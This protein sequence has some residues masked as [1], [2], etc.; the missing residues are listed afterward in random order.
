MKILLFGS[1]GFFGQHIKQAAIEAG[2][3][4]FET[5]GRKRYNLLCPE[6]T[7]MAF[8]DCKKPDLVINAAG[9]NGGLE[10]NRQY[11]ADILVQNVT[12]ANNIVNQARSFNVKNIVFLNAVCA[13]PDKHKRNM[14][15]DMF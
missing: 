7:R 9:H 2:H 5:Y 14:S 1:S 4:V 6:Q 8:L 10:F 11:P 12:M 3:D 15:E 13:Y